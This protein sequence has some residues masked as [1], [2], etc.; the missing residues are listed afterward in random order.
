MKRFIFKTETE[1]FILKKGESLVTT[2]HDPVG[3]YWYLMFEN[4]VIR[5]EGFDFSNVKIKADVYN[6]NSME[7]LFTRD[8]VENLLS[9]FLQSCD[10]EIHFWD[11]T[12]HIN[13][14]E[15]DTKMITGGS[16][17]KIVVYVSEEVS[18]HL[19]DFLEPMVDHFNQ[20][21]FYY[22]YLDIYPRPK[23]VIENLK[24]ITKEI[25]EEDK[26]VKGGNKK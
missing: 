4:T 24:R 8:Q 7:L 9:V 5:C 11:I 6:L 3:D 21:H 15:F 19:Y 22:G 1:T 13:Y 18:E 25:Q 2:R 12:A 10:R 26:K 23:S 14:S 20:I 17:G 16:K